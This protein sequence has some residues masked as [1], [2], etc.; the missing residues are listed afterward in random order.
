MEDLNGGRTL[1]KRLQSNDGDHIQLE[2]LMARRSGG[3]KSPGRKFARRC[4]LLAP[5][6]A[7]CLWMPSPAV[8]DEEA[9][10]GAGNIQQG[11]ALYRKHDYKAAIQ[12]FQSAYEGNESPPYACFNMA[13]CYEGLGDQ[14]KARQYYE[15]ICRVFP[16]SD[17]AKQATKQLAR[18]TAAQNPSGFMQSTLSPWVPYRKTSGGLMVIDA[19]VNGQRIPMMVDTG[20]E[21][22]FI[23]S[24]QL[25]RFGI[26]LK[27]ERSKETMIGTS[28]QTDVTSAAVDL[29]V[30]NLARNVKIYIQDDRSLAGNQGRG[31]LL[32]F[33][34]LG[35]N[36]FGD[37]TME[38]DDR[39][40]MLAFL[41]P[42]E[43]KISS[44][45]ES[46]IPFV[47]RGKD[48]VVTAKV[49]GRECDM[50]LDSGAGAVVFT[51]KQFSAMG[52]SRPIT[53]NRGRSIGVGGQ[54]NTFMFTIDSI[55]LGPVEKRNVS[56]AVDV[57][58]T[59][60]DPLLGSPFLEGLH[61][62]IDPKAR[63]IKFFMP[64]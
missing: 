43:Q 16:E 28:G 49:N 4:I 64:Y 5:W 37:Y 13:M 3:M 60:G 34:L 62:S 23:T 15:F 31:A 8:S 12:K 22:C 48:I 29:Q 24:S 47:H 41:L 42:T 9:A 56:A 35:E 27:D 52:L 25:D 63:L 59:H 2:N 57:N 26:R 18:A 61:Y 40:H 10:G 30:G 17:W 50:V 21:Y 38:V 39:R 46:V 53:A 1:V 51:D 7:A 11:L 19:I 20:A 14:A 44:H 58:G 54:R 36:F 32:S 45:D 55:K 6:L 33:P